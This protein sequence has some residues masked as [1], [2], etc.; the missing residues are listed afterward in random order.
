MVSARLRRLLPV[1]V[2]VVVSAVTI[3]AGL[4]ARAAGAAVAAWLPEVTFGALL[5]LPILAVPLG[6]RLGADPRTTEEFTRTQWLVLAVF[7]GWTVVG[8]GYLA[9]GFQWV[10]SGLVV[11]FGVAGVA[12]LVVEYRRAG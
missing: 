5:L 4:G 1:T 3:A 9:L 10:Y 7:V 12:L 6:S 2:L 11:V 8:L